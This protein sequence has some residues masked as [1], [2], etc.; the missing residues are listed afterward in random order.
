MVISLKKLMKK[1]LFKELI[2]IAMEKRKEF[3]TLFIITVT[4][5]VVKSKKTSL[6]E[7]QDTLLAMRI[8]ILEK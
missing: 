8:T 6:M 2:S 4:I 3:V 5:R 7:F 1:N